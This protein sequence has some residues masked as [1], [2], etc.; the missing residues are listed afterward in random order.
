MFLVWCK[1]ERLVLKLPIPAWWSHRRRVALQA[2]PPTKPP[3][4]WP[5]LAKDVSCMV[6]SGVPCYSQK[7]SIKKCPE[8]AVF[9]LIQLYLCLLM[10]SDF[11][12]PAFV[13]EQAAGL[14]PGS[15]V[16]H[17]I[18]TQT[19]QML[20]PLWVL[21]YTSCFSWCY[22]LLP[23]SSWKSFPLRHHG[24][25]SCNFNAPWGDEE[26]SGGAQRW[27]SFLIWQLRLVRPRVTS[28]H[29]SFS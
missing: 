2:P 25:F 14:L 10:F 16:S 9:K 21:K 11:Y 4:V 22:L 1:T 8:T 27:N 26:A 23:L 17:N 28:L 7:T 19:P 13:A 29:L 20:T 15:P 6:H 18:W 12:F 3:Q 24:G 5:E